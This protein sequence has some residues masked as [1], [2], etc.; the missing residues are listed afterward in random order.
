MKGTLE[1]LESRWDSPGLGLAE[2][3]YA[4][5]PEVG[6]VFDFSRDGDPYWHTSTVQSVERKDGEIRFRTRNT[7][8]ILRP[9]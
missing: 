9:Q 1:G 4:N 3:E 2:I 8:Y 5:E 6:R 7:T